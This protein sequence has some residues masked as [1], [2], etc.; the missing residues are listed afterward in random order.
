MADYRR[1]ADTRTASL[2]LA[3]GGGSELGFAH[4]GVLRVLERHG[5]RPSFLAGTSVGAL[6]A[7]FYAAGT[8]I[9]KMRRL[10][11]RMNWRTVQRMTI[12]V[13]ALSTNEPLR[14]FLIGMLPV[15]EFA[16]LRIP[17]RLVTTDLLT[18]QRVVF[19]GGPA[20]ESR[21]IVDDPDTVFT[22][23]DLVEAIRASCT[24]PVI[25]RPVKLQGRLLVDGCLTNNVPATLVGDMGADVV[26]AVD[27]H[28]HRCKP[29]PPKNILA[30]A[31]Q[32]QA[33]QLHWT[34]KQRK[35]AADV[36]IRPD[37]SGLDAFDF[38][39]AEGIMRCGEEA[40]EAEIPAIKEALARNA[41]QTSARPPSGQ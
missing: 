11:M 22:T 13:L 9:A 41:P 29:K 35:I 31:A 34:L 16:S 37:F 33:I 17:L 23:G 7:A 24:R 36:V 5:L 15:R 10:G 1:E 4:I 39:E 3:L 6:V 32:S 40:A 25:N 19:Q 26:V 12:P 2:G 18:A 8:P 27:L 30:Y 21:G 14:T 28:R 38:S 20:F